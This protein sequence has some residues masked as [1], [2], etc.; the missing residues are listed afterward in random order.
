MMALRPYIPH[1][2]QNVTAYERVRGTF[3][4]RV[5]LWW[6]EIDRVL[7]GLVI[8]LMFIGAMAVAAASPASAKRLS[9]GDVRLDDLY[10]FYKHIG[11]QIIGLCALFGAAMLDKERAR[12]LGITIACI[13]MALLVLVPIIGSEVN[14]AKR[15]INLGISIQPSEL[16]KVGF[17]ITFAWILTWRSRNP[18][19]PVI[20]ILTGIMGVTALL[21]MLQPNLG[22]AIL[23]SGV[24]LVMIILA[25]VSP[26]RLI[27]LGVMG[28]FSLVAAYFLYD[29]ARNRINAFLFDGGGGFDQVYLAQR[30]LL[31]GGWTGEGMWLGVRKMSLPEAHTDYIFSVIGEEFGLIACA[32]LVVIYA[33]IIARVLVRLTEEEDV[34][35]VFAAAGIACQIGGQAFINILVNIQLFPSKG[36][37]LPL[38]SYGGSSTITLCLTIG[39]L[40]ALT[41]RNPFLSRQRQTGA[42]IFAEFGGAEERN[43]L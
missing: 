12:R 13:A 11:F 21:L 1:H 39:L 18:G 3:A 17:S 6:R 10:F 23:F 4:T 38:I 28:I 9:T 34:F 20:G 2:T 32:G 31:S 36:M 8:M 19:L 35:T 25:G 43:K 29:N 24:W 15:W 14:G 41:R 30:T 37:T 16:L 22:E 33:A 27:M 7:L 26:R 40:L 5:K 42:A